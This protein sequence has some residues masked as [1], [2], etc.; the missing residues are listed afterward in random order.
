MDGIIEFFL[1]DDYI[2]ILP[3]KL[4]ITYLIYIGYVDICIYIYIYNVNKL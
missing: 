3:T 2:S 1:L 4:S